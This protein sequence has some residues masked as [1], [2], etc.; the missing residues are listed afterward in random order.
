MSEAAGSANGRLSGRVAAITASTRSIGRGIA[1]AF[2]AEGARVMI[3]GRSAE[4]GEAALQEM[5][6]GD[7]L[8]FYQGSICFGLKA[9]KLSKPPELPSF[10]LESAIYIPISTAP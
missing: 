4:K 6:G 10:N 2:L 5:K 8:D 7:A 3:N 1:E 9:E